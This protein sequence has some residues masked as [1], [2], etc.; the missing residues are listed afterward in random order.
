MAEEIFFGV[1]SSGVAGDLQAATE[2]AAQM[3]GA[4]GMAGRLRSLDAVQTPGSPNLA[5]KVLADED[6][7]AALEAIL[8]S[9]RD[10]V[11]RLL[12]ESTHLVEALRDALLESE[13]L[14]G[15]EIAGVLL[16]AEAEHRSGIVDLRTIDDEV[17]PG[18]SL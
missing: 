16:A 2:A 14:I 9:A 13:E 8:T 15:D 7:G 1:T 17:V 11:R 3:V 6:A 12:G 18:E 4:L 5:A 10:D